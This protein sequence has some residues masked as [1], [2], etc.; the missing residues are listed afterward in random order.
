[1]AE[2]D[3]N[4]QTWRQ[5]PA[6]EIAG[7]VTLVKQRKRRRRLTRVTTGFLAIAFAAVCLGFLAPLVR[8]DCQ[9][10]DCR[11]VER[12]MSDYV[13]NNLDADTHQKVETHLKDC[14][15]CREILRGLG[16]RQAAS[17]RRAGPLL[18]QTGLAAPRT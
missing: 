18:G 13:A 2:N 9:G 14:P 8:D 7:V 4:G 15:H 1:M 6:G 5:C 17:N 12:L 16:G 10:V 3:A 11:Q